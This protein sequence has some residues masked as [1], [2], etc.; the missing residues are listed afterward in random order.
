[1]NQVPVS[2]IMLHYKRPF[3]IQKSIESLL[4]QTVWPKELV[5]LDDFSPY[6]DFWLMERRVRKRI[7]HQI[8]LRLHRNNY[9]QGVGRASQT[10]IELSTQPYI[11]YLDSDDLWA[12]PKLED[13][14]LAWADGSSYMDKGLCFTGI[15]HEFM[16]YF[17][18]IRWQ[19]TFEDAYLNKIPFVP[20]S[21]IMLRRDILA[22]AGGHSP[23]R[24]A[25]DIAT[26]LRVM[27]ISRTYCLDY[28][29]LIVPKDN[30]RDEVSLTG[31]LNAIQ[32]IRWGMEARWESAILARKMGLK[33]PMSPP[34]KALKDLRMLA[35]DMLYRKIKGVP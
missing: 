14:Y 8:R 11:A 13:Q 24:Q 30:E 18:S 22:L 35:M 15:E 17:G 4:D 27:L 3:L 34:R 1:M 33:V 9:N 19:Y 16:Q 25:D 5:I 26:A 21:S 29:G 32:R 7:P 23:L 28:I 12:P 10:A 2:V 31:P 6:D 20:R